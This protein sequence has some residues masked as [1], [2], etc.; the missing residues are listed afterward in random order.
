MLGLEGKVVVVTGGNRGIGASI[1][2]LLED[3]GAKVAYNYRSEPGSKGTLPVKADV[4]DLASMEA[5]TEKVERELGPIYGVVANA[6]ITRDGLFVNLS[7]EDWQ[8]V[9]DANLT[10]VYNT[11]K[12]MVPKMYERQE[13][14]IVA[15][16]SLS[17]DRGNIGQSNYAASKAGIIGMI[18]TLAL[19]AARYNVRANAVLPGFTETDMTK[20]IPEPVKDKI[21]KTIPLRR[22]AKPE[23]IAWATVYFLAPVAG[24][25][26]GETLRING[27]LHT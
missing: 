16:S 14:S 2:S 5:L 12:P 17:G 13:G 23:E 1:V 27:G 19:E 21:F 22:F 10:G 18:K 20:P 4:T 26:T 7:P 24:Y 25:T 8:G 15:I 9:L 11:L 3:L 6:G